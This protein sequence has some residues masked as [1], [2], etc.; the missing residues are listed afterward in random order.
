MFA[1]PQLGLSQLQLPLSKVI[2]DRVQLHYNPLIAGAI[3]VPMNALQ[4]PLT[5][6]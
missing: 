6:A 1:L 2:I 5:P 4:N 3:E